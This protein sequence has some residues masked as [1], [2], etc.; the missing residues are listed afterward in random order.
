M[1][2]KE[3]NRN[4]EK[5]GS[6]SRMPDIACEEMSILLESIWAILYVL[7]M[8]WM[9]GH[10]GLRTCKRYEI[11]NGRIEDSGSCQSPH[12]LNYSPTITDK[13]WN[14]YA[15][16]WYGPQTNRNHTRVFSTRKQSNEDEVHASWVKPMH[17]V[18]PAK[19]NT[20]LVTEQEFEACWTHKLLQPI[21][22]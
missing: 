2:E 4:A 3:D 8:G 16:A 14:A 11:P 20:S 5:A 19:C 7:T 15:D 1:Q 13:I 22:S 21:S 10:S 18:S 6:T 17:N 12:R 9:G